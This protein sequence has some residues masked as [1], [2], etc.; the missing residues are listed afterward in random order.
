MEGAEQSIQVLHRGHGDSKAH[1]E[2]V[3]RTAE[4]NI[5]DCEPI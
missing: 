5:R 3:Q 4:G 1:G 2:G